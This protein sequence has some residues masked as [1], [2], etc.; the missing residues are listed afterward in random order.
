MSAACGLAELGIACAIGTS[1]D[2]VWSRLVA[3]DTGGLRLRPDLLPGFPHVVGA[4]NSS[5][6]E[7]AHALHEFACRNNRLALLAYE[8]I[9]RAVDAARSRVGS[10]RLGVVVGTSTSGI[11]S[12]EVAFRERERCGSFD[13]AFHIEQLEHGGVSEFVARVAGAAGPHYT[14]ST[15]C[16]SSAKALASARS[17]LALDLCDAVIAGGVDSLCTSTALG[18]ASLQAVARGVTNPMSRNRDGLTLGEGAALF[19]VTREAEAIQL[20][21]VGESSDAHH[22]SA[23]DPSSRGVAECM[24]AALRDARIAASAIAY[25][26]LHGTGTDLNDRSESRA[27]EQ[28]FDAMPPCSSTKPLIGHTLGASGALEAAFCWLM[29]SRAQGGV[30]SPPPHCFD[31]VV[32]P[33]LAPLPL[34]ARGDRIETDGPIALM[35]NSFG[36]GGSNCSLVLRRSDSI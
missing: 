34:V 7:P 10:D 3:G 6:P 11:A 20:A 13:A 18:F 12:A 36:F 29:L 22:M 8:Q 9:E 1:A 4:V 19:L 21:G 30:L 26:N 31:G 27:I 14:V 16:S 23:P 35:S 15:A 32:D 24:R 25:L 33:A 28:V 5:L 17:L 2:E